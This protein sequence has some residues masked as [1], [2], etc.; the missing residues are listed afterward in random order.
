MTTEFVLCHSDIA[1]QGMGLGQ[2][3]QLAG[4]SDKT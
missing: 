1:I 4:E 2:L 3:G